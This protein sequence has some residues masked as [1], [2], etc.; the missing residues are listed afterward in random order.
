MHFSLRRRTIESRG[1]LGATPVS[2]WGAL[3]CYQKLEVFLNLPTYLAHMTVIFALQNWVQVVQF[4]SEV[5]I[6]KQPE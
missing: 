6:S 3:L 5:Q 2:Y 4:E 1:C